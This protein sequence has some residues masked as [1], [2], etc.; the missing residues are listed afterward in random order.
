MIVTHELFRSFSTGGTLTIN[1]L[2]T[3]FNGDT[4]IVESGATFVASFAGYPS[5]QGP[6]KGT[7]THVGG[8][9]ASHGGN[10]GES[11]VYGHFIDQFQPGSG[12]SAGSGGALVELNIGKAVIIDGNVYSKGQD[13]SANYGAGS[14]GC[15]VIRTFDLRG[16]GHLSVD[17]G[18]CFI[19][20]ITFHHI[21][22]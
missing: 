11:S 9:Y 10:A 8:S 22:Q 19:L 6:G 3:V 4:L 12:G 13:V 17:G 21:S 20:L 16:K 1:T 15:L 7:S 14:G 2:H 18:K 5:K